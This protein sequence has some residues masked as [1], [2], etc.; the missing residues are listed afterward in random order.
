MGSKPERRDRRRNDVLVRV[1]SRILV[2]GSL[3][4]VLYLLRS[5]FLLLFLVFVFSYVQTNAVNKLARYIPHRTHRAVLVGISFL[6]LFV[7]LIAVLVPQVRDQTVT[8]VSNSSSYAQS[9]DVELVRLTERYPALQQLL[10]K[11]PEDMTVPL[12]HEEW[13]FRNSTL[14]RVLGAVFGAGDGDAEKRSMIGVLETARD[15]GSK[16][17][18]ISSQFLLSL[19]FSFLIVLDLPNLKRG[20]ISIRDTKLRF[21]YEEMAESLVRFGV[22]MG[23]AFEAQFL[24]ATIN[25]ALTVM[26]I[27][28]IHIRDELAFLALVVFICGFIPIAGVFISSVPICLLALAQG[29]MSKVLLVVILITAVHAIES[30]ILNPRIFGT[31]M[32]MN[33][34]VVMILMTVSGKLFGVWG[35]VLCVPIATYLFQDAI[36]IKEKKLAIDMPE[37]KAAPEPVAEPVAETKTEE[38]PAPEEVEVDA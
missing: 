25:T 23:R 36:Q 37:L 31:H 7:I 24:I 20:A 13:K 22:T 27:Y 8:F 18:A 26:G 11:V 21:V 10:P 35:L 1:A 19:L 29:G 38:T 5:F 33:P 30:Y 2:W 6:A 28:L 34:V 14:S 15:M 16:L 32:K 17:L 3:F 4:G 12:P 9:L